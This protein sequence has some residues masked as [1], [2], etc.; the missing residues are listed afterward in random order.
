MRSTLDLPAD[1]LEEAMRVSG[2][3]TKSMTIVMGLQELIHRKRMEELRALGGKLELDL[4]I[5][6]ARGRR[7]R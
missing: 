5:A 3:R 1:L 2:A 6:R 7:K 4:D